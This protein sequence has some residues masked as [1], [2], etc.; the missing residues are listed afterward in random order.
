MYDSRKAATDARKKEYFDSVYKKYDDTFDLSLFIRNY[1]ALDGEFQKLREKDIQEAF[2]MMDKTDYENQHIDC[3][4][5]GSDSCYDMA[6]KIA[7]NVN[8]PMNCMVKALKDM[9]NEHVAFEAANQASQSKSAFLANMSHEIRT[10]M[11]AI[12]GMTSIG[13][14]HADSEKV[15]QC[16]AKIEAASTHLLGVINDIL[17]ISKIESGKF[18]LSPTEFKFENMLQQVVTV[19]NFRIQDRKQNL[20]IHL[21]SSIP[22]TVVGDEQRLAQVITNLLSNAVK[23]TPENGAITIN[24][25]LLNEENGYCTIKVSVTDTGIGISPEQ[26]ALLFKSFQQAESST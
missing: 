14:S 9:K 12:I 3:G 8:I 19:N 21:D 6:R 22:K 25:Y 5:C 11:N 4:A 20:M 16:F 2:E 23:F 15:L 10:P 17:D 1:R 18:E 7:L 13:K 24:T 26:Q